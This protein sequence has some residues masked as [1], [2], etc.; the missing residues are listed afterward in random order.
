[1]SAPAWNPHDA[2][3][4]KSAA[5]SLS[6][7]P[8]GWTRAARILS[9]LLRAWGDSDPVN[10]F[11]SLF[12]PLEMVLAGIGPS[13][14]EKLKSE[15][16][17]ALIERHASEDDDLLNW[18]TSLAPPITARFATFACEAALAGWEED[19]V[20]FKKFNG[21][22]SALMHRG[23]KPEDLRV[24]VGKEDV[25]TLQSIVERYVNYQLFADDI[26]HIRA[27]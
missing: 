27:S 6:R 1:M 16:L 24:T 13:G 7:D 15:K 26:A 10:Q 12:I 25:R 9:W 17:R 11:V 21:I 8:E 19:I 23:Q 4:L 2:E 14:Q 3:P 18:V 5:L 22:R 20:V